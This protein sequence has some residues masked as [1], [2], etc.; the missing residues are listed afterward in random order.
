MMKRW[1][2]ELWLP[3]QLATGSPLFCWRGASS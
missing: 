2:V 1:L 3:N